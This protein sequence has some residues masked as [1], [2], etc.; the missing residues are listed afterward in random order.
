MGMTTHRKSMYSIIELG[1]GVKRRH[2]DREINN[3]VSHTKSSS[4]TNH[5]YIPDRFFIF[6]L[7]T[8][9]VWTIAGR[10]S[11]RL[12]ELLVDISYGAKMKFYNQNI[13]AKA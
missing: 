2:H 8:K 10:V 13:K 5:R 3:K 11:N 9:A 6:L 1:R 12:T 4:M 7:P